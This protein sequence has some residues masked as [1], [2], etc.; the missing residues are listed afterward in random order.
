MANLIIDG[1]NK[2]SPKIKQATVDLK[3]F[4]KVAEDINKSLKGFSKAMNFNPIS[5]GLKLVTKSFDA[6]GKAALAAAAN[7]VSINDRMEQLGILLETAT[8]SAAGSKKAFDQ[9]F[10]FART[11][12]FSV[13][14]IT[15]SF[16]KLKTAGL[17]P[18]DGTLRTLTDSVAAFGG[19]N[20]QLKLV[21]IA[22]QQMVGKGVVSMEELRRQFG[23]QVPTAMRAMAKGLGL[24]MLDMVKV[25]KTGTLESEFAIKAMFKELNKLHGGAGLKRMQSFRG[26][27]AALSTAW[28]ELIKNIGDKGAWDSITSLIRGVATAITN[29]T[30]SAL[31][32]E[33][34]K[35]ISGNI[36]KFFAGFAKPEKI[37]KIVIQV[38]LFV[39]K[40]TELAKSALENKDVIFDLFENVGKAIGVAAEG[41]N[42]LVNSAKAYGAVLAGKLDMTEFIMMDRDEVREFLQELSGDFGMLRGEVRRTKEAYSEMTEGGTVNLD[43]SW[44]VEALQKY[45]TALDK[46][47]IKVDE[48]NLKKLN[49]KIDAKNALEKTV[50]EVKTATDDMALTISEGLQEGI[51]AGI[52]DGEKI[53][54]HYE[55]VV[56]TIGKAIDK[57]N[58]EI[59]KIQE[60]AVALASKYANDIAGVISSGLEGQELFEYLIDQI[61]EYQEKAEAAFDDGDIKK[62]NDYIEQAATF[63]NKL[64][65]T[66]F[67]E[68][69]SDDDVK[70]AE[71]LQ[72]I[73]ADITQ[74]V[75]NRAVKVEK[76][77]ELAALAQ[78]GKEEE[79][80]ILKEEKQELEEIQIYYQEQLETAQE[81]VA[82]LRLME[83]ELVDLFDYAAAGVDNGIKEMENSI[84]RLRGEITLLSQDMAS[85]TFGG[86]LVTLPKVPKFADGGMAQA[87]M[88]HIIGERGPELFVPKNS[89]K[90]VSNSDLQN[91][92]QSSNSTPG[93][94]ITNIFNQDLSKSDITDVTMRQKREMAMI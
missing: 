65:T 22:I 76:L 32:L 18:M 81:Y 35:S 36:E 57:I 25:I 51:E 33:I 4:G 50:G 64:A 84:T 43:T 28:I 12:P 45:H 52:K 3:R 91:M 69:V 10:D 78:K 17:D 55:N 20:E 30:K 41:M 47:G 60:E 14:A 39:D 83:I 79:L 90:V 44:A 85:V 89:G 15:D 58:K 8:G 54:T 19:G 80:R 37:E 75:S 31:G 82:T 6:L 24:T 48:A 56:K 27:V 68:V 93:S 61:E 74:G 26:A 87:G 29:F 71:S 77:R 59:R 2:L 49:I 5:M 16:V 42:G 11:A 88:P 63:A 73:E 66:E 86:D 72:D 38:A 40:L 13:D 46:L 9:I 70:K 23:E 62:Y 1:T 34:I 21:T 53:I 7:F 92:L 94:N 67:G